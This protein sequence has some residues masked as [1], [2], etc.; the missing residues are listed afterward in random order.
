MKKT[1]LSSLFLVFSIISVYSQQVILRGVVS[2][3]AS[4][5]PLI[6]ASVVVKGT[7]RGAVTDLDGKYQLELT[8]G[9]YDIVISYVGYATVESNV[10][11]QAD[12]TLDVP[13]SSS[14]ALTH[15]SFD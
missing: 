6:G 2:D 13:L 10:E 1:L 14:I 8:K 3:L 9:N 7:T 4:K 12:K 15:L 11:M 5:E